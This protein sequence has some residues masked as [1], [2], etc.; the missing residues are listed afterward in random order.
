M[1]YRGM[2][3]SWIRALFAL[4]LAVALLLPTFDTCICAT[5]LNTAGF[6]KASQ[7][8]VSVAAAVSG[9]QL[10]P[11][12]GVGAP[13]VNCHCFHG[14]CIAKSDRVT[15]ETKLSSLES[16][17]ARLSHPSAAPPVELLRPPRV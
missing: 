3:Q 11:D 10:Y 9:G 12:D 1:T 14:V 16:S 17:Q 7:E 6:P 8:F 15:F 2:Q 13:C 5:D 4:C